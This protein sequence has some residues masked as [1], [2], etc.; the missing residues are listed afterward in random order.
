MGIYLYHAKKGPQEVFDGQIEAA[1][2]EEALS[3]IDSL[4]LFPV[5]VKEKQSFSKKIDRVPLKEAAAFT[6]HLST[7]L[8]SGSTLITSLNTLVSETEQARLNPIILDIIFQLKEGKDFSESLR[9]YPRIFS[10]LY[11]SLVKV[12]ETSGTLGENLRR[13]AEFL[14]EDMDF[15]S[16]ITSI[17]T[18]PFIIVGVG[19]LTVFILLKM[20]IPKL[21]AILEDMGQTLPWVTS[22]LVNFSKFISQYGIFILIFIIVLFLAGRR[23]YKNPRY[24]LQW[25]KFKLKIPLFG[26]LL[27]KIEVCRLARTLS[28]L[29]KNGLPMD[30]SLK[31]ITSTV[32]NLFLR[33]AI[34]K[35][36]EE[37]KQG[38]SLNAAMKKAKIFSPAFINVVTVGEDSGTLGIVLENLSNDYNKEI[39]RGIRNLLTFL[40]P[41]LI[42]GVGLMVGFIVLSMLFPVFQMDFNF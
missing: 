28:I 18:Y 16:N 19:L 14:E 32:G 6:N 21:V 42:L 33:H 17:L 20:V 29:L 24:R 3:K 12:G 35:V 37:I 40:E 23:Y 22:L 13:I 30:F 38:V 26:E 9:R 5:W 15:R 36:E 34:V 27:M 4:G 7:L 11:I 41:L 2:E 25:D 8:N 39:N 31:V 10:Q 1:S